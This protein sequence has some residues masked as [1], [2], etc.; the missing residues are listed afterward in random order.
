[1]AKTYAYKARTSSG[2]R[3]AGTIFAESEAAVAAHIREM[4]HYVTG[5]ELQKR[6]AGNFFSFFIAVRTKDL[7]VFCRQFSTMVNA[8]LPLISCFSILIDQ[9]E[10]VKLKTALHEVYKKL[11]EGQSLHCSLAGSHDVFPELMIHM[12]EA[13]ET[14]GALDD[15]LDRLAL[16]FEK[17]YKINEKIKSAMTYP[18][19]VI[20]LA[21]G[22]V[23]FVLTFVMPTFV[24]LFAGL[25]LELPLPTRI[26]LFVSHFLRI[27]GLW[28]GVALCC[29]CFFIS[30]ALRQ[31]KVKTRV[32]HII[33]RLPVA[34]IL[35]KK[36][37]MARFSRTLS[38]LIRGGIPLL[39]ALDVVK[40]LTGNVSIIQAVHQVRISVQ[41]GQELAAAL[42]AGKDIFPP[43]IIQMVAVGEKSGTLE[44]MLEKVAA[45]YE[46]EIDDSF[47]RLSSLV[48]P[49]IVTV[50][51]ILTCFI[52]L[53]VIFPMFDAMTFI[54]H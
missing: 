25:S 13:G 38:T 2:E 4:G 49:V 45:Y 39:Q 41:Q 14:G 43:L 21:L 5:I 48:E 16:H 26:L 52:I 9:T 36:T 12:I 53:T 44:N 37:A 51:G 31:E 19:V 7:A 11:K 18:V 40:K 32:D 3:I 1:M 35:L 27:Y 20:L 42:A 54:G 17:E 50:L 24:Q 23:I 28:L 30:R 15:I 10:N 46:N 34:G 47:S 8:G 6:E 33:L 29:G 22:V